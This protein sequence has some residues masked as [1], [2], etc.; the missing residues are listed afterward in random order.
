MMKRKLFAENEEKNKKVKID[1]NIIHVGKGHEYS[2]I[3]E[4]LK[5]KSSIENLKIFV[6]KG[7]VHSFHF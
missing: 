6:H 7:L 3:N 2:T 5:A 4:A 1:D